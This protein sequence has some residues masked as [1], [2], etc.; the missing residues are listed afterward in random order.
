MRLGK[1]KDVG[2]QEA[3]CPRINIGATCMFWSR[4]VGIPGVSSM[5]PPHAHHS[6]SDTL[7]NYSA[8]QPGHSTVTR[9][10]LMM[11]AFILGDTGQI[12]YK[13]KKLLKN[14]EH[15][16]EIVHKE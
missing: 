11:S 3:Q 6:S 12:R 9:G 10:K 16:W 15:Y 8:V 4:P 2:G 5:S 7:H 14:L 1:D 13:Y